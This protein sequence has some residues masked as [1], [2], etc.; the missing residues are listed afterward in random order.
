ME[1]PMP[2]NA[3]L[4]PARCLEDWVA[5]ATQHPIL[6]HAATFARQHVV[7]FLLAGPRLHLVRKEL[8][9]AL[10]ALKE[11][12]IN[13]TVKALKQDL[14]LLQQRAAAIYRVPQSILSTQ[15]ARQPLRANIIANSRNL[16]N[17]K[18]QSAVWAMLAQVKAFKKVLKGA[19]IIAHKLVL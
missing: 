19:A 12:Q 15:R 3:T 11:R 13:L 14:N 1:G 9:M 7:A 5:D 4:S 8:A 2:A 17:C 16:D 6:A 10:N 18:E